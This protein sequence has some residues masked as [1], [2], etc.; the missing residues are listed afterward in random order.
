MIRSCLDRFYYKYHTICTQKKTP[1]VNSIQNN[2][3]HARQFRLTKFITIEYALALM[4][5]QHTRL[6]GCALVNRARERWQTKPATFNH[7]WRQTILLLLNY[8]YYA[9]STTSSASS[10]CI[11]SAIRPDQKKKKNEEYNSLCAR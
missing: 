6:P 3:N 7:L 4:H 10:S 9:A 1:E 2:R 5:T 11:L 8:Y